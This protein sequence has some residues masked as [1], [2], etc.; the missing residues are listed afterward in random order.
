MI[1]IV[2]VALRSYQLEGVKWIISRFQ[3]GLG[4]ILA[5]EMGLGKTCQVVFHD[6]CII[7]KGLKRSHCLII[8]SMKLHDFH[9]ALI[10]IA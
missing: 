2:E 9:L 10:Y 3:N 8:L 4:C 7:I 1:A 5:D 6:L